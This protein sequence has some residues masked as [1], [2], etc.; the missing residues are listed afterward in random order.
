MNPLNLRTPL[1]RQ[2]AKAGSRRAIE[3]PQAIVFG[4]WKDECFRW[5]RETNEKKKM[6]CGGCVMLC[7]VF[8]TWYPLLM[9]V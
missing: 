7:C 6:L 4:A 1:T 9:F 5:K 2:T 8:V 3:Q